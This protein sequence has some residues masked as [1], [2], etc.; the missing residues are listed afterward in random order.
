MTGNKNHIESN[1][2]KPKPCTILFA[3]IPQELKDR[4]QWVL[5]AYR[6]RKDCWTK[7]P[8]RPGQEQAK[9][10]DPSTWCPFEQVAALGNEDAAMHAQQYDGIG[11]EF[12]ADDPY[13]GI[14]LDDAIDSQTKQLKPWAQVI[15]DQLCSYT[16]T[17]PS[18][19]G[20]KIW[21]EAKKPS[22]DR[23][24]TKHEDGEVEMYDCGRYFAVTG[25]LWPGVP[26]TIQ[27]RQAE[28]NDL[29]QRL[30]DSPIDK[31]SSG[32]RSRAVKAETL[33][34]TDEELIEKAKT[35]KNGDKFAR[36]WAGDTNDYKGDDSRADAAFCT[37][38][39]FWT[40]KDRQRMDR[41]F[42]SSGLMRSKW[43][44]RR[45]EKTYGNRT[46]EEACHLVQET[47]RGK[48]YLSRCDA[49]A[50]NGNGGVNG[51]RKQNGVRPIV[52]LN[53]DEYRV[54]DEAIQALSNPQAAP[55]VF[56]RGNVLV[57]MLRSPKAGKQ[58]HL[59]RPEGTPR[60]AAMPNAFVC[61]L[62]TR[63][64]QFV[65]VAFTKE[66]EKL[67]PAHPPERTVAAVVARGHY[68]AMRSLE[69]VVETPTL[70]P[71]GTLLDVPGWD[72]ETGLLYEPNADFSPIP[73]T[74]TRIQALVAAD[75]LLD[76]V[77]NFPFAGAN[78]D[79]QDIHRAAWLAGLLTALVRFAIPGPCPLF[80]F[81]AN[82]PGT[83]KSLL[84]DII[85]LI[86]TGRTMSRTAFPDD[87][88]ELRKRI[89]SIALAGDKLMLFDN[90]PQ[91]SP[92]GGAALDAALTATT[93]RDRILGRSEMTAELPLH[94]VFYATGNNIILRGDMQRRVIPCRLETQEEKPE[95]RGD[96]KYPHLLEHIRIH[97]PQL[98]CDALTIFRAFTTAGRP[99]T[100]LP[101]FGS[102]EGWSRWIR[103]AVFWVMEIDPCATREKV[104]AADPALSNLAILLAGWAE[105]PGGK[106]GLSVAEALCILNDPNQRDQF[107]TLRE[108]LMEW[109]PNDKLPSVGAIGYKLRSF[110]KRV[111]DSRMFDADV[112][113]GKIHRWK[114]V[115]IG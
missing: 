8:Y 51:T 92:F 3:N 90:I 12:A 114:V 75:H 19:T 50:V 1:A 52:V 91:G 63:V 4:P 81:D 97:R 46:I 55:E 94:T 53:T 38:L 110:R 6:R 49:A 22:N 28:V 32:K 61:E 29:Y 69:A 107:T 113:H 99:Q 27:E 72:D 11:Y 105:L 44:E 10:D 41:I 85:A 15:V 109:S 112:G 104:R 45:G 16:E 93:W 79:E 64:A 77:S 30:F 87:E 42:R 60:I 24:R 21:V 84:T 103:Q 70:R 95:E 66:G 25:H 83:G 76:L 98:V 13:T 56:Q 102:Y 74:P 33:S 65:K 58:S 96:F 14:D 57:R 59:D 2:I 100:S 89:T 43:D 88:A 36:L 82:C 80:V 62:L 35:A 5:W 108:A 68:P 40:D 71:D 39:A 17:S 31:N 111:V 115:Q 23:S 47:Y 37:M 26:A 86:A 7:V 78:R 67:I 34:L 54:N 101:A 48:R 18:G 20:V 9:A 73:P 106:T